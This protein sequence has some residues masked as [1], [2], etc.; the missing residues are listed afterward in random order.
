MGLVLSVAF[1]LGGFV[2][3]HTGAQQAAGQLQGSNL[4]SMCFLF[5]GARCHPPLRFLQRGPQ[6]QLHQFHPVLLC[7]GEIH[8]SSKEGRVGS[9][10]QG[11]L[12]ERNAKKCRMP[13]ALE[14]H[15]GIPAGAATPTDT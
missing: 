6:E 10:N 1:A 7:K 5:P 9:G 4:S 11:W 3:T 8:D 13:W 15:Y 2:P 14:P 12:N